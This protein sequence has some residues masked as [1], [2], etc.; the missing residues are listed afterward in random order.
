MDLDE[1]RKQPHLSASSVGLY[2]ECSLAYKFRYVDKLPSETTSDALVFGSAI[3]KVLEAF[4]MGLMIGDHLSL[5][6]L[7]DQWN[8]VWTE[9]AAER[10]DIQW[11]R[12]N[13]FDKSLE[14]GRG[15]LQAFSRKLDVGDQGVIAVEEP[16]SFSIKGLDVPVIGVYDLVLEDST[17]VATIVDHKTRARALS[18]RDANESIQATIY[19]MAA[20]KNG[21]RHNDLLL[22]FDC[23][24]KTKEPKFEQ[25]YT[26]RSELEMFRV[27]RLIRQV[28][29]GIQSEVWL[30]N[31]GSWKCSGCSYKQACETWLQ[32]GYNG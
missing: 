5:D 13:S 8:A 29:L 18:A 20:T 14:I 28:W 16:F 1:L 11:K 7:L 22:R 9:Q 3:H 26:T 25:V 31:L 4:Y 19:A 32:E 12:G 6:D 24:I 10:D 30:P 21:F 23:M 2:L 15:L 27:A 17:G